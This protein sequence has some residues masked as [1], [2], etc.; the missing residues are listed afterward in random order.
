MDFAKPIIDT[1]LSVNLKIAL[2]F[3]INPYGA[4]LTILAIIFGYI[5]Y[6]K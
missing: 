1:F 5:K 6:F 4:G 2:D 3:I